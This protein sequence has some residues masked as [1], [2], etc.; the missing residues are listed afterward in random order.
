MRE[1]IRLR[2]SRAVAYDSLLAQILLTASWFAIETAI[3]TAIV[4]L[5]REVAPVAMGNNRIVLPAAFV[6]LTIIEIWRRRTSVTRRTFVLYL[7]VYHYTQ[8][9]A[10]KAKLFLRSRTCIVF[11]FWILTLMFAWII[12]T[13]V[14]QG[15]QAPVTPVTD[16]S[17]GL[18]NNALLLTTV[19][20][21]VILGVIVVVIQQVTSLFSEAFL[22]TVVGDR[23]FN[24]GIII[25]L[26]IG[27]GDLYLFR[28][29]TN[30]HLTEAVFRA[31]IYIILMFGIL[32]WLT[33]YYLSMPNVI[34]T[35]A[36]KATKFI[37]RSVPKAPQPRRDTVFIAEDTR[38]MRIRDWWARWI[39]GSLTMSQAYRLPTF[40]AQDVPK[41]VV[42]E[43]EE[44]LRP[45]GSALLTAIERDR[46]EAVLACLQGFEVAAIGYAEIRKNYIGG[47][48]PLY[49][50]A[51]SQYEAAYG[52][53][54]K[55]SNQQ[56]T[57]DIV[58]SAAKL[59]YST[60]DL[61]T[62]TAQGGSNRHIGVW[63]GFLK[64]AVF[65][66]FLLEH[67]EAPMV[68]ARHIGE[69]AQALLLRGT[70][71]T[72]AYHIA[73]E[74]RDVGKYLVATNLLYPTHIAQVCVTGLMNLVKTSLEMQAASD[75]PGEYTT[76]ICAEH[77]RGILETALDD[78]MNPEYDTLVAPLVGSLWS[79]ELC[80]NF[81]ML[82]GHVLNLSFKEDRAEQSMLGDLHSAVKELGWAMRKTLAKKTTTAGHDFM[83]AFAEAV[84]HILEY[85]VKSKDA[86]DRVQHLSRVL[87]EEVVESTSAAITATFTREGEYSS[88]ELYHFSAIPAL[89][90]YYAVEKE[91]E[92]LYEMLEIPIKQ[93]TQS[94]EKL[95]EAKDPHTHKRS[96]IYGYV[97]LF[98][99]WLHLYYPGIPLESQ[100]LGFLQRNRSL[101]HEPTRSRAM[102]VRLRKGGE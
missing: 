46:R 73:G 68:A 12:G 34:H 100:V 5:V 54:L 17:A 65:K 88:S 29:G 95:D 13:E 43:I 3:A 76:K 98:G 82:T 27:V 45:I 90:M 71:I 20:L 89:L 37:R 72:A 1:A 44:R 61:K 96:A 66:T 62:M 92:W 77:I 74:V 47:T 39:K 50:F 36:A 28:Y 4:L 31:T 42:T 85:I 49:F 40:T 102:R 81:P 59:A 41:E 32:L 16:Q 33:W 86:D 51:L 18:F 21:T 64:R 6:F 24:G 69:I 53:A 22:K 10:R 60:V 38:G 80:P 91:I 93:L 57:A 19:V 52:I 87:L 23:V 25:I 55:S 35:V 9:F 14:R 15:V 70:D 99:A 7:I 58:D 8:W 11:V 94:Y 84:F 63:T 75:W 79:G 26:A 67:T 78:Q 97:Q 83:Q 30:E 56:Y 2:E 101:P 48:D